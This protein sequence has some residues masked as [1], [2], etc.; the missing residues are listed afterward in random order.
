MTQPA[1]APVIPR[2]QTASPGVG[3][4]PDTLTRRLCLASAG[5]TGLAIAVMIAISAAG[6]SRAVVSV[7]PPAAG[8]PW[9]FALHPSG[10][11]VTVALWVALH[12]AGVHAA[13][14]GIL[15]AAFVPTRPAPA[16]APLLAQAASALAALESAEAEIEGS[17]AETVRIEQEPIWDWA[18]RN[19]TAAAERLSSPAERLERAVAPWTAYVILPLFAFSATGIGLGVDAG[20]GWR[21]ASV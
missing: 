18:S 15:L 13:L 16:A 3:A 21:H 5:G 8:A 19:L 4:R 1:G 12:G 10:A 7:P 14:A 2:R 20:R 11:L 6:P 17:G 9:E